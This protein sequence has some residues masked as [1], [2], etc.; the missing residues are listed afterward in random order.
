MTE[1]KQKPWTISSHTFERRDAA[2]SI[3]AVVSSDP[4]VIS[5]IGIAMANASGMPYAN[6]N[7]IKAWPDYQRFGIIDIP[8]DDTIEE[9]LRRLLAVSRGEYPK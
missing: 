6:P 7:S 5:A 1:T 4:E 8:G 9:S 2:P 3:V